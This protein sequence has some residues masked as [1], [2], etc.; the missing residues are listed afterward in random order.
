M[1]SSLST[2]FSKASIFLTAV[3]KNLVMLNF[4]IPSHTL[5]P[6]VPAGTELDEWQG[7]SYVSIVGFQFVD[8]RVLGVPVPFHSRFEE[9]N[10]RFYVRR[11]TPEGWR[12][13][14][15]FLREIV[16]RRL[17]SWSARWLYRENYVTMPMRH[18]VE[19]PTSSGNS[20]AYP[21]SAGFAQ[22]EWWFADRWHSARVD[23]QGELRPL[24]A[25]SEESFIAEH[26]WG[27]TRWSPTSTLEYEV[28]HPSWGYW[29]ATSAKFDADVAALYGKEFVPYLREPTSAF[30]AD[31]S[32]VC[33]YRGQR[34]NA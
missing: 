11:A 20:D 26:Y 4:P 8:T 5:A 2:S 21:K 22:Y 32:P 28:Q 17:I 9:V 10:L 7:Q 1:S 16:P 34:V 19:L 15:V 31:G 14:V 3:W 23:I 13:G 6:Y 27:Y 12:R 29:S 18:Q 24:V 30:I 25:N 33:V